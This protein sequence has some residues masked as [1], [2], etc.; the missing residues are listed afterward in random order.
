VEYTSLPPEDPGGGRP[1]WVEGIGDEITPL[2]WPERATPAPW[3]T[4]WAIVKPTCS[5]PTADIFRSPLLVRDRKPAIVA[6]F[7]AAALSDKKA[8]SSF[9]LNDLQTPAEAYSSEV[10]EALNWVA[11]RFGCSRMT[12]SGSAVFAC[13]EDVPAVH[14]S[15]PPTEGQ[16]HGW[17]AFGDLPCGWSGKLCVGLRE[18]PLIDWTIG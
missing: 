9:G 6:D 12:G 1:A 4:R 3:E 18:H 13:A 17:P 5:I 14:L 11:R 10:G 15:E 16:R 7:L 2:D 8:G